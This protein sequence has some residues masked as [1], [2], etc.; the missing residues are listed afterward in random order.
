MPSSPQSRTL[1]Q[2][3]Q[4]LPAP[5]PQAISAD[6]RGNLPTRASS[7]EHHKSWL[8]T[9]RP[10]GSLVPSGTLEP[11]TNCH[12]EPD[13]CKWL[14]SS[15]SGGAR[16]SGPRTAVTAGSHTVQARHRR[17]GGPGEVPGKA[18]Q[19]RRSEDLTSGPPASGLLDASRS[20]GVELD[21]SR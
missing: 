18:G 14:S 21:L 17:D 10:Q 19:G 7:A 3:D 5:P 12:L 1:A 6:G 20:P 4:A 16:G 8:R 15:G 9:R 13:P 11:D 2:P